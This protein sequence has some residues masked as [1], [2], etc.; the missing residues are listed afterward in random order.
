MQ[1]SFVL[2]RRPSRSFLTTLDMQASYISTLL[3]ES[4]SH[5][6]I[7]IVVP[8]R[9]VVHLTSFQKSMIL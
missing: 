6:V 4:G 2:H 1:K 7:T 5:I 3:L 8:E 9:F